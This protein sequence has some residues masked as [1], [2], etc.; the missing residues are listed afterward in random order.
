MN[1]SIKDLNR[2]YGV[3][4]FVYLTNY[5]FLRRQCDEDNDFF[6]YNAETVRLLFNDKVFGFVMVR[7]SFVSVQI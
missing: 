5:L 3:L 1:V 6:G 2:P 7:G 4:I